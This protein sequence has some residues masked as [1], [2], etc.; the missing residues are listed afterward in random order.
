MIHIGSHQLKFGKF[1]NGPTNSIVDVDGVRVGQVTL[2]VGDGPLRPG[3]GPVRTGVSVILPTDD[4]WKQK[5]FAGSFVMNGNGEASGLMWLQESGI[6]ET[7]I[8]FTNTLSIGTVQSSL[9]QWM[10]EKY[11]EMGINDD[12]ITPVVL[13]C[14]DSTLNDIRGMHVK[15]EHVFAA[16]ADMS[17]TAPKE[18]AVGAGTGMIAYELKGGIGSSS[19]KVQI[20]DASYTVAVFLNS[21][22]GKRH[23]LNLNGRLIGEHLKIP[24]PG[25]YKDGSVAILVATDAPLDSRQLNRLC[26]RAFLGISRTGGVSYH[27]SGD[28]VVAFS[29]ANKVAHRP[30]ESL[31][32]FRFLSDFFIDDLF[33]AA[34]DACEEA[35]IKVLVNAVTVR[36]RDGYTAFSLMEDS[37]QLEKFL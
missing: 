29:T 8:A 23:T 10:L 3:S 24:K 26:K 18:G 27:S 32:N 22:H 2:F 5:L 30:S 16:L 12:V 14:D 1:E 28:L 11:P 19:R 7:P 34:S 17:A 20:G 4:I 9:V 31:Q 15:K 33:E 25:K 36:G 21:N 35:M 37:A 13:E 6:L